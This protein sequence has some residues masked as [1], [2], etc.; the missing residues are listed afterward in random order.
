MEQA[1]ERLAYDREKAAVIYRGKTVISL[2][3][4][5][6]QAPARIYSSISADAGGMETR[7]AITASTKPFQIDES[8][9]SVNGLLRAVVENRFEVEGMLVSETIGE[10][11]SQ[12]FEN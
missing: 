8:S 3:G 4:V 10:V 2:A 12:L 1:S 9:L 7:F 11:Y 5:D 6:G